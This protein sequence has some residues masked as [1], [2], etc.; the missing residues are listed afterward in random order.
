[1]PDPRC[2]QLRICFMDTC[3]C[4]SRDFVRARAHAFDIGI[5]WCKATDCVILNSA[6]DDAGSCC[7]GQV[8]Q[9]RRLGSAMAY[10]TA[11]CRPVTENP[12]CCSDMACVAAGPQSSIDS[13]ACSSGLLA[14]STSHGNF[15]QLLKTWNSCLSLTLTAPEPISLDFP[16]LRYMVSH[17]AWDVAISFGAQAFA[18]RPGSSADHLQSFAAVSDCKS[19]LLTLLLRYCFMQA[20]AFQGTSA[21]CDSLTWH[22]RRFFVH[23]QNTCGSQE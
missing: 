16:Y 4:V 2:H 6:M 23:L 22:L 1:M 10:L 17:S 20:F 9:A 13:Q 11:C 7:H 18:F 21:L 3:G 5:S 15:Q 14:P 8:L 19:H 12:M